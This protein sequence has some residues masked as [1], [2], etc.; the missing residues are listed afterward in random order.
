MTNTEELTEKEKFEKVNQLANINILMNGTLLVE[1][2]IREEFIEISDFSNTY[3]EEGEPREF[4]EYYFISE[5]LYKQLS[6]AS[7]PVVRYLNYY[8]WARCTTGQKVAHDTVLQEIALET[9]F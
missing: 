1:E 3:D 9:N 2:L 7:K 4:M 6:Y 8:I 5:W